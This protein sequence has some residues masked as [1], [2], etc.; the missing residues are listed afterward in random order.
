MN[1]NVPEQPYTSINSNNCWRPY[2]NFQWNLRSILFTYKFTFNQ[3]LSFQVYKSKL[4][5]TL[6]N[7]DSLF[8]VQVVLW[9][10]WLAPNIWPSGP[11]K[12]RVW[13]FGCEG[14][15]ADTPTLIGPSVTL[16]WV[17]LIVLFVR[18]PARAVSGTWPLTPLTHLYK[19]L[20]SSLSLAFPF[21]VC[22]RSD[23]TTGLG[24]NSTRDLLIFSIAIHFQ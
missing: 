17:L 4:L 19:H 18:A 23:Q 21:L 20:F 2:W 14:S 6:S 16:V 7:R 11:V 10:Q 5:Y 3:P 24:S 13:S 12:F 9:R 1:I 8:Y 15:G 22:S